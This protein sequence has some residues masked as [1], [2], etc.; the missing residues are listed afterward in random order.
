MMH[1]P[2]TLRCEQHY[3]PSLDG[4]VVA[5]HAAAT[6]TDVDKVRAAVE[7]EVHAPTVVAIHAGGAHLAAVDADVEL[8]TVTGTTVPVAT[9]DAAWT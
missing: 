4:I 3:H 8:I 2:Q 9:V 6:A 1:L 7:H 5:T